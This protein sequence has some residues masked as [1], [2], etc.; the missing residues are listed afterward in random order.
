LAE[1]IDTD[2]VSTIATN[3]LLTPIRCQ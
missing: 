1:A 2:C 3:Y